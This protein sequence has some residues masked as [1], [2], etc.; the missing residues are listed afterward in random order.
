MHDALNRVFSL[1]NKT[2]D[3]CIVLSQSKDEAYVV[4][5]LA[6]YERMAVRQADVS[7][8]SEDELLD[9]INRDI[10]VWK[11]QQDESRH[12]S[13]QLNAE[14]VQDEP[15]FDPYTDNLAD[16]SQNFGEY[17]DFDD[18]LDEQEEPF[19]FEKVG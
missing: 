15:D 9:K 18:D 11:S 19:Y 10:A 5:S 12:T 1:I 6:E 17:D 3:R 8:L 4:M 13:A 7:E 16:T 14:H 2:G